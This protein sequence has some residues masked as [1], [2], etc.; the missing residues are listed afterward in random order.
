MTFFLD[1]LDDVLIDTSDDRKT[2]DSFFNDIG[3]DDDLYEKRDNSSFLESI[4]PIPST[5][6][7]TYVSLIC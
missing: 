5:L 6:P 2:F 4:A 1:G 7:K 3:W